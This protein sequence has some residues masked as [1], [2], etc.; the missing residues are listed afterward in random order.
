MIII[1]II[2]GKIIITC[3]KKIVCGDWW[4]RNKFKFFFSVFSTIIENNFNIETVGPVWWR[5][6]NKEYNLY[7]PLSLPFLNK[8]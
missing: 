3:V 4:P 2:W 8:Q 5:I 6:R 7:V 1:I